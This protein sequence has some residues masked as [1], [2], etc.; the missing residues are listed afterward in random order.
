LVRRQPDQ[1]TRER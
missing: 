1:Y